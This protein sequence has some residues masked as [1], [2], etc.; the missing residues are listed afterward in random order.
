[1]DTIEIEAD[2]STKISQL[3]IEPYS[4]LFNSEVGKITKIALLIAEMDCGKEV[5]RAT[6]FLINETRPRSWSDVENEECRSQYLTTLLVPDG[7]KSTLTLTIGTESICD[8]Y[9]YCNG[10]LKPNSKFALSLRLYT[11]MGYADSRSYDIVTESEIPLLFILIFILTTMCT[12]FAI[13]F[14]ISFSRT[15]ALR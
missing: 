14:Y 7:T 15:K 3:K 11:N 4:A 12:V 10:P 5:E 1:M 2:T 8:S 6:G 13:G 9:N